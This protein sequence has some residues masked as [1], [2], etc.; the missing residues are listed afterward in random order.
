[1]PFDWGADWSTLE[2]TQRLWELVSPH[3]YHFVSKRRTWAGARAYCRGQY[4][5]MAT[6]SGPADLEQLLATTEPVKGCAWTGLY[7]VWD[8]WQWSLGGGY[9]YGVG[10]SAFTSWRAGEPNNYGGKEN[11]VAMV[12][13]GLWADRPCSFTSY[14]VCYQGGEGAADQYFL[15]AEAKNWTEALTFCREHYTDLT[16]VRS[17]SENELVRVTAG[18][19][20]V[21]IGLFTEPWKWSDGDVS[22]FRP[23]HVGEPNNYGGI[24]SCGAV[25]LQGSARGS[26]NDYNCNTTYAFFCYSGK[27]VVLRVRILMDSEVNPN[28]PD[29]KEWLLVQVTR[30]LSRHTELGNTSLR[31]GQEDNGVVFSKDKEEDDLHTLP[32]LSPL[33]LSP[34]DHTSSPSVSPGLDKL[35]S[36]TLGLKPR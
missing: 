30:E 12:G 2:E 8:L 14:S 10:R 34:L 36:M 33:G 25:N 16:R 4:T 19:R 5:D 28:D 27:R 31:W 32:Q 20:E 13:G 9:L 15:V 17:Q 3:R 24:E 6:V 1:M 35:T 7:Y 26:W 23:W 21:W 11:C 22:T 18:G 29:V